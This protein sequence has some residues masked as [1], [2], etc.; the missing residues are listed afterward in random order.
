MARGDADQHRDLAYCE[1]GRLYGELQAMELGSVQDPPDHSAYWAR[2]C[3]Q[4]DEEGTA[5]GKATM[6]RSLRHKYVRRL[7]EPDEFYDLEEDPDELDNR[8]DDPRYAT[9]LGELKMSMLDWYQSTCDVVPTRHDAR[10]FGQ[11][12]PDWEGALEKV[13][14]MKNE[15]R[16]GPRC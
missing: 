11:D 5:H 15:G 2:C 10:N 7:Y 4:V 3:I 14:A 13:R 6:V 12:L 8:I 16:L 1:G 9:V